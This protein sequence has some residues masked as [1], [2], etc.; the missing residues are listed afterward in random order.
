MKTLRYGLLLI[1]GVIAASAIADAQTAGSNY[2]I[3][4]SVGPG[5]R[6][7]TA[8]YTASAADSGTTFVFDAGGP[9]AVTLPSTLPAGFTWRAV[10]R[11]ATG[12]TVNAGTGNIMRRLAQGGSLL[13]SN[14]SW[15][16][17]GGRKLAPGA[18]DWGLDDIEGWAPTSP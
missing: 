13:T 7:V 2:G 6:Y 4:G 11:F 3:V 17:A 9:Y 1:L 18:G 16:T 8:N 14:G 15:C 10:S 5:V 12:H